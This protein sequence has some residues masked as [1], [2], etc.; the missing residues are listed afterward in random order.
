METGR[1][2]SGGRVRRSRSVLKPA[3]GRMSAVGFRVSGRYPRFAGG[4]AGDSFLDRCEA[5]FSELP[6][7]YPVPCVRGRDLEDRP[8]LFAYVHPAAEPIF[9]TDLDEDDAP[10]GEA[11]GRFVAWANTGAVGPGYHAHA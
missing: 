3:G 5:F 9:V 7:P 11:T 8:T 6:E 2:C 1:P 10:V 4:G